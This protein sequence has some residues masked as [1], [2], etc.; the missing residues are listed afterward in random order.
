M[1]SVKALA[2]VDLCNMGLSYRESPLIKSIAP[3]DN[4]EQAK[5]CAFWYDI[6]RQELLQLAPWSFAYTSAVLA[7]D[8]SLA[9]VQP[10]SAGPLRSP[11]GRMRISTRMT[12]CRRLPSR[13]MRDND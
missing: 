4:S 3:P 6:C 5:S 8:A 10:R 11:A 13:A 2:P 12:V 7:V 1:T 9:G